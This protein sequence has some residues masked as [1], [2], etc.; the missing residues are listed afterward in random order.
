MRAA[1]LVLGL[2]LS[3]PALACEGHRSWTGEAT[4]G[5]P[6]WS[7]FVL[8]VNQGP[9]GPVVRGGKCDSSK[10]G[11][12]RRRASPHGALLDG[13]CWITVPAWDPKK[14]TTG[15][16]VWGHELGHCVNGPWHE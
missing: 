10:A 5:G 3:T 2:V 8:H 7:K 11:C 6:V 1:A 4:E 15:L 16:H 14:L 12:A 13:E 9:V